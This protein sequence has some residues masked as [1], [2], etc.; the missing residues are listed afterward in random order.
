MRSTGSSMRFATSAAAPRAR[1]VSESLPRKM[2]TALAG[3]LGAPSM[4]Q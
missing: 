4:I 3:R 2:N 1:V